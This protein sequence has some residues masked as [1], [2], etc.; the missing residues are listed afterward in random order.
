MPNLQLSVVRATPL[1]LGQ[2]L[3]MFLTAAMLTK[4]ELANEIMHCPR[5]V[6]LFDYYGKIP[7]KILLKN[8]KQRI[9]IGNK[10]EFQKTIRYAFYS[11]LS[12]PTNFKF[13]VDIGLPEEII[14]LCEREWTIDKMP[15]LTLPNSSWAAVSSMEEDGF[16][17][18][19]AKASI[20]WTNVGDLRTS[21][22]RGYEFLRNILNTSSERPSGVWNK[23]D[24]SGNDVWECFQQARKSYKPI[25]N[26]ISKISNNE[27]KILNLETEYSQLLN[28]AIPLTNLEVWYDILMSLFEESLSMPQTEIALRISHKDTC[29]KADFAFAL[30]ILG[31]SFLAAITMFFVERKR[32]QLK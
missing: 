24:Y 28:I 18:H 20:T 7:P 1:Q 14:R 26:M 16:Y 25:P 23:F 11:Y 12:Y 17:S 15:W 6:A 22:P 29:K 27:I 3:Y 4:T 8:K 19:L 5:I 10:K 13:L 31:T 9:I 2:C 32:M 30:S 21:D